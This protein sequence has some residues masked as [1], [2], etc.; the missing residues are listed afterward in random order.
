MEPREANS[1][2]KAR[3]TLLVASRIAGIKKKKDIQRNAPREILLRLF[4]H[5]AS[6]EIAQ[7]VLGG[8]SSKGSRTLL[9]L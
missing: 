7:L 5:S 4:S 3:S 6:T 9:L 2:V 1:P 8:V